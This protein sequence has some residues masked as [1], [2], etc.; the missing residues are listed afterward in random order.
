M[1]KH[2]EKTNKLLLTVVG[3]VAIISVVVLVMGI[4]KD[5]II[6]DYD[7]SGEAYSMSSLS[8]TTTVIIDDASSASDALLATDIISHLKSEGYSISNKIKLDTEVK[9]SSLEKRTII[10]IRNND[11]NIIIP[12]DASSDNLLLAAEVLV[13]VDTEYGITGTTLLYS[14]ATIN[15]VS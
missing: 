4:K 2:E 1:V 7:V 11:V 12:D 8:R 13:Y 6:S 10:I 3:L 5:A 15:D 14:E 9:I